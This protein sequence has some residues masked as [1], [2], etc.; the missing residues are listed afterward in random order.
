MRHIIDHRNTA[1]YVWYAPLHNC[2]T[3]DRE[4]TGMMID[5]LKEEDSAL[6]E[7]LDACMYTPLT[8]TFAP[9]SLKGACPFLSCAKTINLRVSPSYCCT[10]PVRVIWPGGEDTGWSGG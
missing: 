6:D 7:W 2:K 1:T 8:D 5:S 3:K 9:A 10:E 4:L